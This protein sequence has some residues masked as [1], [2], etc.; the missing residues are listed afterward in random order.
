MVNRPLRYKFRSGDVM[1]MLTSTSAQPTKDWLGFCTTSRAIGRV[2]N[3]LRSE[4][5]E[6]SIN[7]GR[8]LLEHEL[9]AAGMSY[10]KFVKNDAEVR[11]LVTQFK[12]N[13]LD[14]MLLSVGYGKAAADDIT[15]ALKSARDQSKVHR[16]PSYVKASFSSLRDG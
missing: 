5:R 7:L 16:R 15:A 4:Q 11:R 14:D 13:S 12:A 1:E 10:S 9:R 6:K 8:E 2:R 3:F